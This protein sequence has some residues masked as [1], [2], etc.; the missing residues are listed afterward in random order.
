VDV[1][2]DPEEDKHVAKGLEDDQT[3]QM[4]EVCQLALETSTCP[5][6]DD[7]KDINATNSDNSEDYIYGDDDDSNSKANDDEPYFGPKGGAGY[8]ME[9]NGFSGF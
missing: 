5:V 4:Q 6:G 3:G 9:D 2:S 7:D 1:D 8:G